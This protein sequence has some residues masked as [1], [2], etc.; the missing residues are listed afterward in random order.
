M[1]SIT[2]WWS[3]ESYPQDHQG[4]PHFSLYPNVAITPSVGEV[5]SFKANFCAE[6][7]GSQCGSIIYKLWDSGQII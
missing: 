2:L 1:E 6:G 7:S 3:S 5:G 4:R